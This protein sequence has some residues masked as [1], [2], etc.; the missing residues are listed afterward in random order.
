MT[1]NNREINPIWFRPEMDQFA[2]MVQ[3]LVDQT[4]YHD[5]DEF[6]AAATRVHRLLTSGWPRQ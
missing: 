3:D 4:Y 2:K 1:L 5:R 6:L